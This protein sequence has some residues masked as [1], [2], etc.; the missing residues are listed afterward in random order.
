MT[1]LQ[2][3]ASGPM[4]TST[5]RFGGIDAIS[6]ALR[7][8]YEVQRVL[9]LMGLVVYGDLKCGF[10]CGSINGQGLMFEACTQ[11]LR[12]HPALWGGPVG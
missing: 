7:P 1:K 4:G 12:C 8:S 9:W 6:P 2:L 5:N 3:A 10:S 11:L